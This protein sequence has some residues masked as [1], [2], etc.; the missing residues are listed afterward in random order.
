MSVMVVATESNFEAA[1]FQ[2]ILRESA[3]DLPSP[4]LDAMVEQNALTTSN[5]FGRIVRNNRYYGPSAVL[6][7][8][9]A[10]A[11]TSSLGNGCNL[12]LGSVR[13]LAAALDGVGGEDQEALQGSLEKYSASWVPEAHAFQR[14]EQLMALSLRSGPLGALLKLSHLCSAAGGM[15]LSIVAPKAFPSALFPFWTGLSSLTYVGMR[16]N[17]AG[18]AALGS[19][20]ICGALYILFFLGAGALRSLLPG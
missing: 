1:N 15:L 17:Y 3:S 7:G 12:G 2:R 6:V 13:A 16:R 20:L 9:A 5:Q 10:H 4:W 18:S 19:G 11:V 8:D 14:M